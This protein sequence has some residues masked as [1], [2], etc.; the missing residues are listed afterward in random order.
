MYA[1]MFLCT[2]VIYVCMYKY[3]CSYLFIYCMCA[4]VSIYVR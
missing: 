2:Y 4:D 3:V 1:C